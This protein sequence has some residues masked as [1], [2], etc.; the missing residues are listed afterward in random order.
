MSAAP[1]ASFVKEWEQ[2]TFPQIG[3]KIMNATPADVRRALARAGGRIDMDDFAALISPAAE[4]FLEPMAQISHRLTRERFGRTMQMFAPLYLTNTCSN[5]CVYCGFN[6]RNK[7][8]RRVLNDAEIEAE[9][10]VLKRMGFDHV[11][12]LTGETPRIGRTY[13]SN[14]ARLLR[15]HFS[16]IAMEVQSLTT[17]DY[18]VLAGEGVSG[19]VMFQETYDAEIYPQ[20]HL[21]GPKADMA[22]RLDAPD[23]M[24]QAGIKKI[25]L[26]ALYGLSDWRTE[27]WFMAL[28]LRHLEKNYWRCRCSVSF[29]RLRPHAGQAVK[30]TPF[31]E[32]NLVQ[33]I[34]AL[35]LL[36]H[37]AELTLS[38]RE[39]PEFRDH[40][41]RLGITS[42]SAASRTNPGGYALDETSLEQFA[43]ND[44]RSVETVVESLRRVGY[45]P[46]W[47]DW[48][49]SYDG[50][51]VA[52]GQ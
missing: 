3:E 36:S 41:M 4:A 52:V 38:T 20:Y 8:P 28:H 5:I 1:T 2:Y 26:G 47:K 13:F 21:K 37:E 49:P 24:G 7:I 25:G 17:A 34:T 15:P 29:P 22:F 12:F 11:L 51:P 42:M 48:D 30:V 18:E 35:R 50:Q 31:G 19:V 14:A 10:V 43:I 44:D 45:E 46:V 6:A 27:A 39:R 32:R 23:R 9:I 16:S 33:A 40:A